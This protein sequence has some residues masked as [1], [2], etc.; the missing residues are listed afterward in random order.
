[1]TSRSLLVSAQAIYHWLGVRLG[2][3]KNRVWVKDSLHRLIEAGR[4]LESYLGHIAPGV[5]D[6]RHY[7]KYIRSTAGKWVPFLGAVLVVYYFNATE[8]WQPLCTRAES[9]NGWAS[10]VKMGRLERDQKI[11][12][13]SFAASAI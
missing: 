2:H 11:L 7:G 6:I 5:L 12:R 9:D 13:I 10:L 8:D 1:M 3:W 4:A